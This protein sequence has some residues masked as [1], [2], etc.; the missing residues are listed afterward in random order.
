[1]GDGVN[2]HPDI[3]KP[4]QHETSSIVLLRPAPTTGESI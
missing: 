1:M 2:R 4:I 3:A